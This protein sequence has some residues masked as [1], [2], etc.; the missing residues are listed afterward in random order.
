[1]NNMKKSQNKIAVDV[2]LLPPDEIMDEAIEVNQA[3]IKTFDN[4]PF[5]QRSVFR[6]RFSKGFKE[7]FTKEIL[8][9]KG[10]VLNKEDC[11][12]HISLAMGC[13]KKGDI[14]K[15]DAILKDIAKKFS[16][17]TLNISDIHA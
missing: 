1:M 9:N 4:K 2:V 16:P 5:F 11:F 12:P 6:K 8:Y 17:I 15:I 13:I 3:L 14:T 10:I 7:S